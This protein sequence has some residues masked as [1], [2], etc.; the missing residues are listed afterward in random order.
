MFEGSYVALITPMRANGA[1]DE[2]AL[3]RLVEWHISEGTNGLVPVGTTGE[4]PVLTHEE[5]LR[6]IELVTDQVAGRVPVIAGCGSNNTAE[7]AQLHEHAFQSGANGALHVTGYYNRPSQEGIYR[8][9]ATLSE[10]NDLPIIV[11]NIPPRA[12]VD[13]TVETMARLSKLPTVVG[14]KDATTDLARPALEAMHISKPF[15]FLSGEDATA[16]A[17]NAA[18]G[19]GCI[20]VTANVMPAYCAKMQ[21]ACLSGDFP[22]AMAI[23]RKLMPLHAALFAEPSPAGIKYACSRIGLCEE[24]VRLPMVPLSETTKNTIDSALSTL[25]VM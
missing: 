15:S 12:V 8:H 9:F 11:Y 21:N 19:K 14:V 5:H 6:V 25:G 22:T 3:H 1:V 23:Q 17:Y 20:S 13:I 24:H 18:G 10:T 2:A 7:A 16:V 4:S